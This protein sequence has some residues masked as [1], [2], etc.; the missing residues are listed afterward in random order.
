M[1][2]LINMKRC[3]IIKMVNEIKKSRLI[4]FCIFFVI[5]VVLLSYKTTLAFSNLTENQQITIDF[6]DGKSELSLDYGEKEI[7]HLKDV[8]GVMQRMNNVFYLSIMVL[9]VIIYF[10][11]NNKETVIKLI[12]YGSLSSL[13]SLSVKL[14]LVIFGFSSL[15]TIF[16]K[17]FFQQGNW[18]F[19]ENS[20]IIQTFPIEFFITISYKIFILALIISLGVYW[21]VRKL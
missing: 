15:F 12:K 9:L 19:P 17:V 6:L 16:H 18:T 14:I 3:F 5:F 1:F 4:I 7:S 11:R 2:K 8:Q 13:I 21:I 20:L 10:N